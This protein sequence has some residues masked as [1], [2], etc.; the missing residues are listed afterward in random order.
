MAPE[1]VVMSGFIRLTRGSG[2]LAGNFSGFEMCGKSR[3]AV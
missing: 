3:A 2:K 1:R